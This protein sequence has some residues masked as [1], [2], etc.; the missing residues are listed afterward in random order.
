M[1]TLS[2]AEGVAVVWMSLKG[3]PIIL[4]A[5]TVSAI[6]H[7]ALLMLTCTQMSAELLSNHEQYA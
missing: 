2:F 7:I 4:I 1:K 3:K 6:C 5:D